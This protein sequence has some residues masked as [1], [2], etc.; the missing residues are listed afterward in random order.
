[1]KADAKLAT[2]ENVS[3]VSAPTAEIGRATR[4]QDDPRLERHQHVREDR[5]GHEDGE[6]R[7]LTADQPQHLPLD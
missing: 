7:R 2:R 1:M 4:H 3:T 5:R 6:A